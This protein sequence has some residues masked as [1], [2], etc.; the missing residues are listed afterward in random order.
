[1]WFIR[2]KAHA[3]HHQKNCV[4]GHGKLLG[5]GSR[6]EWMVVSLG[7]CVQGTTQM[8]NPSHRNMYNVDILLCLLVLVWKWNSPGL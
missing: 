3:L 4:K 8:M 7:V 1:M 2:L 5:R 6:V